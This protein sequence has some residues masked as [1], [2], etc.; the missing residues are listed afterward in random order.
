MTP[1]NKPELP[2]ESVH[3]M[4][5][6]ESEALAI[7]MQAQNYINGELIR[8]NGEREWWKGTN[9][10]LVSN[11]IRSINVKQQQQKKQNVVSV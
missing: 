11:E 7:I 4:S 1:M 8:K 9:D 6:N 10:Q 2:P 3:W 5:F